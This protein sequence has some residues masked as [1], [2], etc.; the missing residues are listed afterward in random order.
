MLQKTK[1]QSHKYFNS[2]YFGKVLKKVTIHFK[3]IQSL[4]PQ[5]S[6]EFQ[7]VIKLYE[8]NIQHVINPW[9]CLELLT[10]HFKYF[11]FRIFQVVNILLLKWTFPLEVTCKWNQSHK[12]Q[13]NFD[14]IVSTMRSHLNVFQSRKATFFYQSNH[15]RKSEPNE[16]HTD[17]GLSEFWNH[18]LC[19]LTTT[20]E[21]KKNIFG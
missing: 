11:Y 10:Q 7:K 6:K 15:L 3:I 13:D 4:N 14:P 18:K 16:K 21:E 19:Y 20:F 1:N 17:G 8:L 5:Y 2:S 9:S 12:V